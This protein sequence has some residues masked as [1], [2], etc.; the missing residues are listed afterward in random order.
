VLIKV[1]PAPVS[2]AEQHTH[3]SMNL[4]FKSFF[5]T[6]KNFAV[7]FILLMLSSP[8]QAKTAGDIVV[9]LKPL[10]SLVAQL[11][12]GIKKPVLLIKQ[13][14]SAHHYNMRPSDRRL[15]ANASM[16]VWIGP[17]MES[18]L[19]KVIRQQNAI[20]VTA[21][22][23]DGLKLLERR[24]KNDAQHDA[25]EHHGHLDPHIWLSAHNA[26]AISKHIADQLISND[27]ANAAKY[28]KNLQRLNS[29]ISQL[30]KQI[31]AELKDE[32]QPF[33]SY[34]DAFQYFEKENGL[35]YVDAII[36]DE[37][38]GASLKHLRHI[39]AEIK[40]KQIQCLLYQPP[41]PAIIHTLTASTKIK[42]V[43]LDPLGLRV[44]DNENA[45]FE[46]MRGLADGFKHCLSKGGRI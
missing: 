44:N 15:L 5:Y 7:F 40:N 46:I 31:K 29:K 36:F 8:A 23:A 27:P 26:M 34:H 6:Q 12:D 18:Y 42:A 33:L 41:E 45:W 19:D 38:A 10:Y 20:I 3:N 11:S 2:A 22:Q 21:M 9:T 37:E 24:L 25:H 30:A 1:S 13:M 32:S 28:Q 14:P 17:Q 16:I 43:A 4:T 35:H 39:K